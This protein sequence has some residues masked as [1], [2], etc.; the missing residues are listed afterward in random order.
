MQGSNGSEQHKMD[1]VRT[2]PAGAEEWL[3]PD[4]GRRLL[5][6]WPPSFKTVVLTEGDPAV[7]HSGTKGEIEVGQPS[8][9]HADEPLLSE[10]MR[11]ALDE[12]DFSLLDDDDTE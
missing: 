8:F 4:C 12:L 1:L 9:Q 2:H 10:E 6:Q 7:T 3:C 11:A 5:V